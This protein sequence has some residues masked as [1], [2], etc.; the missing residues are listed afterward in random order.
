MI[1]RNDVIFPL[2]AALVVLLGLPCTAQDTTKTP[3]SKQTA[4]SP[5]PAAEKDTSQKGAAPAKP[6]AS[7]QKKK[8]VE[9]DIISE[10][11]D[12]LIPE[13]GVPQPVKKEQS[14]P[15]KADT[16]AARAVAK[17]AADTSKTSVP[18]V[19]RETVGGD[20]AKTLAAPVANT[21]IKTS[22]AQAP[23]VPV[24]PIKIEEARPINFAKNFKEYRSPQ[25][26]MLMSLFVPGLGQ[27]YI[28][29]Y[30]RTG[31][32]L[33]AEAAI[34]GISVVYMNKGKDKYKQA[35]AF[36]DKNF[37]ADSMKAYY[38]ALEKFLQKYG[39]D[40]TSIQ[41][42]LDNISVDTLKTFMHDYSAKNQEFYSTIKD[43]TYTQGWKD[44]EPSLAE[45]DGATPGEQITSLTGK[46]YQNRYYRNGS[47]P[48]S[49]GLSYFVNIKNK[50]NDALIP[51]GEMQYGYSYNQ[52]TF[53]SLLSQSNG[54]YKT[55]TN[56]LFVLLVNHVVSAVD[57]L[58]S[59]NMYNADLL[60]K[61]TFWHHIEVEPGVAGQDP[62]S[63]PGL[64]MRI[65]F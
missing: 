34:I 50:D 6:S 61:Q 21:S 12:M 15:A 27:A 35:T 8:T 1:K 28:K 19:I 46:E 49:L 2:A 32:Y 52:R 60:G 57:A 42:A 56:V 62:L 58:I 43:K 55:A 24:K 48:D 18:A 22:V 33:A 20:S 26:A 31:L 59:A 39:S 11:E 45:I 4:A 10:D 17:T 25:M 44:C 64:T 37:S 13:K 36:A 9:E 14:R 63:A 3:A 51:G 54:N 53:S 29:S 5:A 23:A 7:L 65:R 47:A 40:A 41:T 38:N 30:W 16:A